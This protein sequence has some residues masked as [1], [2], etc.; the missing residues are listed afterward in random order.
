M[1]K[2]LIG[3]NNNY[4]IEKQHIPLVD[5]EGTVTGSGERWDVHKKGI[6]H[7]GFTVTLKYQNGILL[8]RRKHPV[9]D[10]VVDVT[11]SS[12]PL[13]VEGKMEDEKEAVVRCL[14]REW[15]ITLD[16]TDV[17]ATNGSVVYKAE[18]SAGF[19]EHEY[20]T[21]Y[22]VAIQE[23]PTPNMEFAYGFE[24]IESDYFKKNVKKWNLA[25]WIEQG[26]PLLK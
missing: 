10:D 19:I 7:K 24:L 2:N 15:G 6:L 25:P 12:H 1:R 23:I 3:K 20:C 21:F 26:I 11:C 9:F 4:Y 14:S 22:S 13:M 5:R 16:A 18:D 17:I 8:Q